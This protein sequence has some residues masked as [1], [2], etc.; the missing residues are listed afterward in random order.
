VIPKLPDDPAGGETN[1]ISP[2]ILRR[3]SLLNGIELPLY[4]DLALDS[5]EVTLDQGEELFKQGDK[6][7]H[8]YMVLSGKVELQMNLGEKDDRRIDTLTLIEGQMIGWSAFVSPF[9]YTLNA[10]A[11][12]DV[13]LVQLDAHA[14][15]DLMDRNPTVGYAVTRNLTAILAER[16][17]NLRV[18]FASLVVTERLV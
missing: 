17:T 9:V 11:L 15:Q 7:S 2:E 8:V 13:R 4:K 12:T 5:K 14:L 10:V 16:L 3:F 6:A 1:M 18:Q